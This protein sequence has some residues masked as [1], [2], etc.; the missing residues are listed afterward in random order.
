MHIRAR[1]EYT[2]SDGI[3]PVRGYVRECASLGMTH[4]ALTD[5]NSLRG[6]PELFQCCEETGLRPVP[7]LDLIVSP[8]DLSAPEPYRVTLIAKSDR[9]YQGLVSLLAESHRAR[10]YSQS[11]VLITPEHI[12]RKHYSH[13]WFVISGGTDGISIND[14]LRGETHSALLKITKYKLLFGDDFFLEV[15]RTGRGTEALV[16]DL[17]ASISTTLSVPVIG[18]VDLRLSRED[19]FEALLARASHR[20]RG[21]DHAE[22]S[23]AQ[24]LISSDSLQEIYKDMPV[25]IRSIDSILSATSVKTRFASLATTVSPLPSMVPNGMSE[26][27][28]LSIAVGR[29]FRAEMSNILLETGMTEWQISKR[30]EAEVVQIRKYGLERLLLF[31]KDVV[32]SAAA[33]GQ[34]RVLAGGPI[35]ALLVTRLIG[36]ALPRQFCASVDAEEAVIEAASAKG[37]LRFI[38][39]SGCER[40]IEKHIRCHYGRARVAAVSDIWRY[41]AKSAFR[42]S[43][44]HLGLGPTIV[45]DTLRCIQDGAPIAMQGQDPAS[46]LRKYISQSG[47]QGLGKAVSIAQSLEGLAGG[48]RAAP[49]I[50]Y[51]APRDIGELGIPHS[52][53]SEGFSTIMSSSEAVI[54]GAL[55]IEISPSIPLA[56]LSR[57]FAAGSTFNDGIAATARSVDGAA[58]YLRDPDFWKAFC[59]SPRHDLAL[60]GSFGINDLASEMAVSGMDPLDKAIARREKAGHLQYVCQAGILFHLALLCAEAPK[61]VVAALED[62]YPAGADL[63]PVHNSGDDLPNITQPSQ[64]SLF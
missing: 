11:G 35:G 48:E 21:F 36:A 6:I 28:F 37:D 5:L 38:V 33:G 19:D 47:E 55:R 1:S 51:M 57:G 3:M 45:E 46:Q 40:G 23:K 62:V 52:F 61:E 64:Q 25:A 54:H 42:A 26:F 34:G 27:S 50:L 49:G 2:F 53:D 22:Y 32:D 16:N 10:H 9:G 14:L 15:C 29:N 44:T 18:S 24:S 12:L 58:G 4:V 39:E 43:A 31:I 56:V 17:I 7:G 20:S 41:G 13:D 60:S 63:L 30:I 59:L 8:L